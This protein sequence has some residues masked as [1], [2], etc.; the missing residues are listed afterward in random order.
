MYPNFCVMKKFTI[1]LLLA[2]TV[3]FAGVHGAYAQRSST[4]TITTTKLADVQATYERT[5]A[6]ALEAKHEMLIAP[7]IANVEVITKSKTGTAGTFENRKFTGEYLMSKIENVKG[8]NFSAVLEVLYTQLKASAIYDFCIQEQAD[9]IVMPQFKITH[10]M[11]TVQLADETGSPVTTEVPCERN[12]KYVMQI[13]MTG[14][15]A[16]YTGF[17]AGTQGDKWIKDLYLQGTL[18][19][20]NVNAQLS[21]ESSRKIGN[22]E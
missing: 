20:S 9:L 4:R 15:P 21:E 18:S 5:E 10:K 3:L 13:E 16:R 1:S 7:L 2:I 6:T 8:V 22:K 11:E 14:F 19:N 17:R 12:G